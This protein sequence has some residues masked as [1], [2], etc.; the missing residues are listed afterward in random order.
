MKRL[1]TLFSIL[2]CL[3]LNAQNEADNWFFGTYAG[4][5]FNSGSPVVASS[6]MTTSEG[7]ASISDASGNLLFYTNGVDVYDSTHTIMA[8]G[9]NLKGDVSTTQSAMI[10]PS[11]AN[12]NQYYIFTAAA[13]GGPNGFCYSIV[14]MTLNSGSGDV[15][16]TKNV[17]LTDSISEKI[18]AI[19]IPT[20]NEYWIVIHKWGTN[21]FFAYKLTSAGVQAPV[22]TNVGTVH[23][24]T[25]FQNTYGQM[26]FNMCGDKLALALGYMDQAEIYDF[27]MS[28]GVVSN[29]I[30]L[31]MPDHVYGIE[32]S[33]NADYL[34]VTCYD[35]TVALAQFDVS[36][37]VEATI[38]ASMSNISATD[39]LYGLQLGPD[40]KIYVSRSFSSTYLGVINSP[41]LDG[42]ACNYVDN[43]V[44]LDPNFMGNNGALSLPS[45]VQSFLGTDVGCS[46]IPVNEN[47]AGND[48][49]ITNDVISQGFIFTSIIGQTYCIDVYDLNGKL[50]ERFE[51][52][53]DLSFGYTYPTGMY[54]AKIYNE[55]NG[56]TMKLMK[57]E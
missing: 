22:I 17:P 19:K 28:T 21:Q 27:N 25:T 13:D 31:P 42:F 49:Y 56:N 2:G 47:E 50:M 38:Q 1:F 53:S 32:F 35:P 7:T 24:T 55:S 54:I 41:E 34:Y 23:G 48:F 57:V 30:I 33:K 16:A 9:T 26:K 43:A 11:P 46:T 29:P 15:T 4:L 3:A 10:V 36:S 8:N 5:D 52:V 45:F 20:S 6:P 14:D 37:G 39:D 12:T 51:N 44:D 40:E 18:A